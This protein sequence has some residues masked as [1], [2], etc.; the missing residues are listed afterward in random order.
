MFGNFIYLIIALL[1]YTTYPPS[2][3]TNFSPVETLVLF[4][5][6]IL[7]FSFI[8]WMQF[9]RLEKRISALEQKLSKKNEVLSEL[10][11]EHITLKKSLGEL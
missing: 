9:H 5:F 1:I 6:L 10:M 3:D 11:E 8:T 4:L 7:L 2:E